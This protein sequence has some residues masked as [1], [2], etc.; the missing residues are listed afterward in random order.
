ML[1][2]I[3]KESTIATRKSLT[4]QQTCLIIGQL[5]KAMKFYH[6]LNIAHRDIKLENILV[7]ME[8]PQL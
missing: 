2:E 8:H 4:E 3:L 5:A 6:S 7:D 1:N